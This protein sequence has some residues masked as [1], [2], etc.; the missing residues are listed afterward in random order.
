MLYTVNLDN[1]N[2]ILSVA[3]TAN[4]NTELDLDSMELD[5]LE[6]YQLIN[7]QAVLNQE[8]KEEIIAER[9]A[10]EKVPTQD[11]LYE[12][13]MLL[14]AEYAGAPIVLY[15]EPES[16]LN[17]PSGEEIIQPSLE[18]GDNSEEN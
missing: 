16:T 10:Q 6:A 18:I 11:E 5:Y 7:G 15:P 17:I 14:N 8:R 12:A 3:H 9:E 4:D 13:Q 2:F 1:N